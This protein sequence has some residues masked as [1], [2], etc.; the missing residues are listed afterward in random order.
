VHLVLNSAFKIFLVQLKHI[1]VS[2]SPYIMMHRPAYVWAVQWTWV[3]RRREVEGRVWASCTCSRCQ[4]L[5]CKGVF[6]WFVMYEAVTVVNYAWST[7]C[8]SYMW[9]WIIHVDVNHT[10]GRESYMWTWIIHVDVNHTWSTQCERCK[11]VSCFN[12]KYDVS[13]FS[14]KYEAG[15]IVEHAA[16]MRRIAA[17]TKKQSLSQHDSQAQSFCFWRVT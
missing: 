16:R 2:I 14:V 5:C 15:T 9:T 12:V 13:C 17:F 11:G 10:C 3:L 8:E 6:Q 1:E 4:K 7:Q